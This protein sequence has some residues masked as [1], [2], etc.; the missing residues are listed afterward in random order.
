MSILKA[1][2]IEKI[3]KSNSKDTIKALKGINFELEPG[4]YGILGPNGAGKSTLFK[5]LSGVL[6]PDLGEVWLDNICLNTQ[7]NI[8]KARLGYMPQEADPYLDF[9]L[10]NFLSYFAHL[11]GF[12]GKYEKEEVKRVLDLVL[13]SDRKKQKV[14]SLSGGMKRRLMLAQALIGKPSLILL[15]EPTAGLDPAQ[16]IAV[17]NTL[18]QLEYKPIIL[19]STH[20]VSDI[21]HISKEVLIMKEGNILIKDHPSQ[22]INK[23]TKNAYEAIVPQNYINYIKNKCIV[24]RMQIQSDGKTLMRI[25]GDFDEKPTFEGIIFEPIEPSLE[26]IYLYIFGKRGQ[27]V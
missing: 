1:K 23:Y 3:Y 14:S 9:S 13:L 7:A 24:S 26:D 4:I 10:D 2:N 21:E 8:F 11:K 5:I 20:V 18:T 15:D 16:R 19:I 25:C 17:R 27:N 6:K 12:V 22:I